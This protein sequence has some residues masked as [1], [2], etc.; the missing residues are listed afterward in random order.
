MRI[1]PRFK[2]YMGRL[3]E[4]HERAYQRALKTENSDKIKVALTQ[5]R[6]VQCALELMNEHRHEAR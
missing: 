1:N 5:L 2:A 4:R 6:A 3:V